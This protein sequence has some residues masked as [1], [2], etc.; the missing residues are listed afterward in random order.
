MGERTVIADVEEIKFET[1]RYKS[2]GDESLL[3]VHTHRAGKK[4]ARADI[5]DIDTINP[6]LH[7]R[8]PLKLQKPHSTI[9]T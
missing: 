9:S 5:A 2:R 7:Q 4:K 8:I 6:S 1:I 3:R